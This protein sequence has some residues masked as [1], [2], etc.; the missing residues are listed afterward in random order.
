MSIK[1]M[2]L[3]WQDHTGALTGSEKAVLLRMAD[4]AAD[5]GTQIFPTIKRL[6]LDTGFS[7]RNVQYAIKKLIEKKYLNKT[8]RT[9]K[10]VHIS[11]LYRINISTLQAASV[12]NL[13][14][15]PK[16]VNK[17]VDKPCTK[18]RGGATVAPGVVQNTSGGGA[19]IACDPSLIHHIDPPIA[20]DATNFLK[21]KNSKVASEVDKRK[22]VN[23]LQQLLKQQKLTK[24]VRR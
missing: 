8:V 10:S 15:K 7:E 24:N 16:D 17:P 4:F 9:S 5:N 3:V 2:S 21:N 1:L 22:I 23:D 14:K 11:N 6:A 18:D 12:D 13:P 19:R 20:K